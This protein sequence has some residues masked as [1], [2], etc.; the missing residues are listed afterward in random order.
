MTKTFSPSEAALSIFELAK[1]QPQFVLRF[2]II[3]ALVMIVTYGLAGAFGV[4]AALSNYIALTTGGKVP[5]PE[6]VLAVLAPATT[7]ITVLVIF[8]FLTGV[9]TTAMGL[10]KA[11]RDED[12]G[13]FGLQL[14]QDELRLFLG[15]A[16][17]GAVLFLINIVIS[18]IGG[19]LSLGNPAAIGIVVLVSVT[20]MI[21]IG[22]RLS[23]FGV[24]TIG[25]RKIG[26]LQSWQETKG[27]AWRLVGAYV[28]WTAI[29]AV[30]G[31][32]AQ[33]IGSLGASFMG[34]QVNS[35]MPATFSAFLTPGW[36]FYAL[37]YGLAAGLG[38]LGAICIGAYAWHQMRGD[39]PA[40]QSVL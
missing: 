4:G 26:V 5:D 11:V 34:T 39:L 7:G 31:L 33:A 13:F 37:I 25:E 29:A 20:V 14:G 36:M 23:Q 27:Q 6:R 3:Y 24:I 21:I 19:A 2:C 22:V 38:N 16:M 40:P 28:L 30:I 17:L 12:I 8:G 32:L 1:R 18:V 35:G 15:M 10:R 9:L